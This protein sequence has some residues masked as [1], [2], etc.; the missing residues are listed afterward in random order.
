[1]IKQKVFGKIERLDPIISFD[2]LKKKTFFENEISPHNLYL[3]LKKLAPNVQFYI[4]SPSILG[5]QPNSN[6]FVAFPPRL[7]T[8]WV[9][10]WPK[11][12]KTASGQKW[13]GRLG[14]KRSDPWSLRV[15]CGRRRGNM[16]LY[17]K[18]PLKKI[19]HPM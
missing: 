1:M 11:V 12:E 6:P 15:P 8:A 9:I 16:H 18:N 4:I 19:N 5:F 17:M 2:L 3:H 7:K 10:N 14:G 13:S